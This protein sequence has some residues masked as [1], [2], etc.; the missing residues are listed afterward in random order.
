MGEAARGPQDEVLGDVR[1][2]ELECLG[3]VVL[4]DRATVAMGHLRAAVGGRR[5][6]D[7]SRCGNTGVRR[8]R[9]RAGGNR[10]RVWPGGAGSDGV[11][12]RRWPGEKRRPASQPSVRCWMRNRTPRPGA[13]ARRLSAL[14]PGRDWEAPNVTDGWNWRQPGGT[15][16]AA[17]ESGVGPDDRGVG[18]GPASRGPTS[19]WWSDALHDPGGTRDAD[20]GGRAGPGGRRGEPEPVTDPDAGR[21]RGLGPFSSSS[22]VTALLAGALGGALGYAFAVRGGG[23]GRPAGLEP[24]RP[25]R[26]PRSDRPTRW[27]GSPSGAAQRR[28]RPGDRRP[29]GAS[30]G[31]GFVVTRRRLRVT[32]DH[33]VAGRHTAR[34]P[35]SSTTAPPPR[36]RWSA[37]TPSRTS[38]SSRWP[39]PA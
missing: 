30:V 36:R 26:R 20:G 34:R 16:D 37:R 28:H 38:R 5:R 13:V 14:G 31:S 1:L 6:A 11:A 24:A 10:L 29:A 27:P 23:A 17:A 32:N 9:Q 3:V 33:V 4:T 18:S 12:G 25:V 8:P 21:R 35:W 39:G 19:P 2:G 15:R 22:L 7:G